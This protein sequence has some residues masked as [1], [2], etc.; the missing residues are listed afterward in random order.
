MEI[1][2]VHFLGCFS[3]LSLFPSHTARFYVFVSFSPSL[4]FFILL[5]YCRLSLSL[6]SGRCIVNFR[7]ALFRTSCWPIAFSAVYLEKQRSGRRFVF[8]IKWR[9][10]FEA[11]SPYLPLLMNNVSS[12]SCDILYYVSAVRCFVE[13]LSSYL[14]LFSAYCTYLINCISVCFVS[15]FYKTFFFLF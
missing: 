6:N 7:S 12:E 4:V 10:R 8:Y 5:L 2:R 15:R 1:L 14:Q 11:C 13:F 3:C 9:C